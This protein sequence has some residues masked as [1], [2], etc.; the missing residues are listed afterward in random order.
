ML[1]E[2]SKKVNHLYLPLSYIFWLRLFLTIKEN[3]STY[4]YYLAA[5]KLFLNYLLLV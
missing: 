3:I 4:I 1:E 5:I 2:Q